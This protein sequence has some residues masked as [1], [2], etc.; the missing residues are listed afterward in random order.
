MSFSSD[1][2]KVPNGTG[3]ADL[4][5]AKPEDAGNFELLQALFSLKPTEWHRDMDFHNV[6]CDR[7]PGDVFRRH[8]QFPVRRQRGL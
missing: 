3:T 1:S 2:V 7:P 4:D 5:A 8:Q 6:W